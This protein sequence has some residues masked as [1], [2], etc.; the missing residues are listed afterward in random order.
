MRGKIKA[1]GRQPKGSKENDQ[2]TGITFPLLYSPLIS[3]C[4][5]ICLKFQTLMFS[6]V[7]SPSGHG[8][9]VLGGGGL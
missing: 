9:L 6:W 2:R 1:P 3:S 8:G 5:A 7:T 4:Q